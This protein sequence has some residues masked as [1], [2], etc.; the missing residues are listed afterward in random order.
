[1]REMDGNIFVSG[2]GGYEFLFPRLAAIVPFVI[3]FSPW[4]EK[5]VLERL[6]NTKPGGILMAW[7]TGAHMVLKGGDGILERFSRVVLVAPFL[8]FTRCLPP[9]IVRAMHTRMKGEWKPALT[10]FYVNCG[11]PALPGG[12]L[13]KVMAD[14]LLSGLD[15]LLHSSI[16]LEKPL[17]CADRVQIIHGMR[18]TIVPA[19]AIRAVRDILPAASLLRPDC[20]HCVLENHLF[21]LFHESTDTKRL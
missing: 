3:P 14:E 9:R 17:A 8:D 7:S 13:N 11:V 10:E 4:Q 15:Y 12:S 19:R 5:D 2:W 1:M 21:P 16:T 6:G 18:D 20:G